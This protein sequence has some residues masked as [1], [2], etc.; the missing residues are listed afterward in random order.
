MWD[1]VKRFVQTVFTNFWYYDHALTQVQKARKQKWSNTSWLLWLSCV[2]V[3]SWLLSCVA[4]CCMLYNMLSGPLRAGCSSCSMT[5]A[6]LIKRAVSCWNLHQLISHTTQYLD[7]WL[8][9]L[10]QTELKMNLFDVEVG[11][12]VPQGDATVTDNSIIRSWRKESSASTIRTQLTVLHKFVLIDF[13]SIETVSASV[14]LHVT[15][16]LPD[17]LWEHSNHSDADA[18]V[19][20]G[21]WC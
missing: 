17:R 15:G 11:G 5:N 21:G 16:E 19:A 10:H 8:S 12:H 3:V 7:S 20:S 6:V 9:D 14:T 2:T 1:F 13:F 18:A 4:D